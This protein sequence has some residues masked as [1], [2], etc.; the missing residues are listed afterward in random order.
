MKHVAV[1]EYEGV[2]E[3]GDVRLR[4]VVSLETPTS[5]CKHQAAI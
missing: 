5:S 1:P 2:G 4:Y 3:T